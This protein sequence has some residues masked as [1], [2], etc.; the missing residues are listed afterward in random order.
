[1]SEPNSVAYQSAQDVNVRLFRSDFLEFFTRIHPSVPVLLYLPLI[2][3]FLFQNA[4]LPWTRFSLF[5][6]A[7]VLTWSLTEYFLHRF[8]FHF[9]PRGAAAKRMIFLIHGIHHDYPSDS[10]RLVMPPVISVPIAAILLFFFLGTPGQEVFLCGFGIGYL[11]YD[12]THY[13]VHH[14]NWKGPVFLRL[15]RHH[16]RHHFQDAEHGFGVSSPLWDYFFKSG[17]SLKG[18]PAPPPSA[19]PLGA[20]P[21]R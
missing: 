19:K 21:P 17:F 13:A 1:M 8:L 9:S 6:A 7:G 12:L 10:K 2:A 18:L 11:L 4:H 16:L 3:Y 14:F 5:L 20:R 15:K